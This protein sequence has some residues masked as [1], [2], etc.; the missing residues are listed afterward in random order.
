MRIL[1]DTNV[2]LDA[3]MKRQPWAQSAQ[4]ILIVVAT[5]KAEGCI[6][7]SSFTDILCLLRKHLKD[8]NQVKKTLSG[9]FALVNVLDVTGV[10]CKKA[11]DLP[12]PDYEDALL[13]CCGK[14]HRVDCIVTRNIK[15]FDGSPL[16]VTTPEEFL[17]G[18]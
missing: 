2:L 18:I 9:L 12:M 6:T 1:I 7:S 16:A 8:K 5:G 4:D 11:F 17:K 10:D 3:M 14:R 13:A 15:H